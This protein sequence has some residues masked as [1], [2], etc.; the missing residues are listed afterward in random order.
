MKL[1]GKP[2]TL[3]LPRNIKA[4]ISGMVDRAESSVPEAYESSI[5]QNI[6][7]P[8]GYDARGPHV[9]PPPPL[10]QRYV[11]AISQDD[12][13]LSPSI[14]RNVASKHSGLGGSHFNDLKTGIQTQKSLKEPTPKI[15]SFN[16]NIQRPGGKRFKLIITRQDTIKVVKCK[17]QAQE[18]FPVE[19]QRLTFSGIQLDNDRTVADYKIQD[20]DTIHLFMIMRRGAISN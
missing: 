9:Y 1:A 10:S 19:A 17:L 3:L 6:I 13:T 12:E 20:G 18:G 4:E 16:I 11:P 5:G 15:T 14:K 8:P 7:A 2:L